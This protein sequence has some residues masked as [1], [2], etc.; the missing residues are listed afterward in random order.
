MSSCPVL[1][2][3]IETEAQRKEAVCRRSAGSKTEGPEY[4]PADSE[5]KGLFLLKMCENAN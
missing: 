5:P 4:T 1:M 2:S 3:K